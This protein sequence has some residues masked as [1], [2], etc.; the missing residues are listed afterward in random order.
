MMGAA[1]IAMT[2]MLLDTGVVD[3]VNPVAGFFLS[4]TGLEGMVGYK[5][6]TLVVASVCVQLI[7]LSRPRTAKAVL[8]TG[9]WTQLLVVAYSAVLLALVDD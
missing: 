9:I 8:H 2:A 7:T 6:T 1:D 4:A 3:E 5:C